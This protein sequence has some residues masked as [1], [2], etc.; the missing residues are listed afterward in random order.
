LK[1]C[2]VFDEEGGE[3][4]DEEGWE[5]LDEPSSNLGAVVVGLVGLV[6][7][8][9]FGFYYLTTRRVQVESARAREAQALEQ[10]RRIGAAQDAFAGGDLDG[11]GAPNYASGLDALAV[12]APWEVSR[13]YVFATGHYGEEGGWFATADPRGPGARCFYLDQLGVIYVSDRPL[14]GPLDPLQLPA[15]VAPLGP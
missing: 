13:S 15:G 2:L 9:S 14:V 7:L 5:D 8:C 4:L 12:P 3:V 1:S 11:D 6:A 10:L